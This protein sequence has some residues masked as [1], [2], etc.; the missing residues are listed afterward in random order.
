MTGYSGEQHNATHAA[1]WITERVHQYSTKLAHQQPLIFIM[2]HRSVALKLGDSQS[3]SLP[4]VNLFKVR[5]MSAPPYIQVVTLWPASS[6]DLEIIIYRRIMNMLKQR[7]VGFMTNTMLWMYVCEV[8]FMQTLLTTV[9]LSALPDLSFLDGS[10]LLLARCGSFF[11]P[12]CFL[13]S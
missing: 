8:L 13:Q 2:T 7:P 9:Y 3:L 12:P 6:S 1:W 10:P 4:P 11:S 5:P